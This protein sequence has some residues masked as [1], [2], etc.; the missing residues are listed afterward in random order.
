MMTQIYGQQ[1]AIDML[2]KT[3]T[4]IFYV[5]QTFHARGINRIH[6][7]TFSVLIHIYKHCLYCML[8]VVIIVV[9]KKQC[10]FFSLFYFTLL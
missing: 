5:G 10:W 7:V 3:T 9:V 1:N 8:C 4:T 6:I 2:R